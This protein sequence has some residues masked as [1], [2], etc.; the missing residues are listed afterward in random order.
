MLV[1]VGDK[2]MPTCLRGYPVKICSYNGCFTRL[3]AGDMEI[4]L[5]DGPALRSSLRYGWLSS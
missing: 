3:T 4:Y 5:T 2:I 1:I